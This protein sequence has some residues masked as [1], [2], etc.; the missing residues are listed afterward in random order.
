MGL[1]VSGL[2]TVGVGVLV[3]EGVPVAVGFSEGLGFF[4]GVG[5]SDGEDDLSVDAFLSWADTFSADD[6]AVAAAGS[7]RE[8]VSRS[9]CR[10]P[11]R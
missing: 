1:G 4:V 6:V 3:G 11:V 10:V 8:A 5:F 9:L 2:L 7:D